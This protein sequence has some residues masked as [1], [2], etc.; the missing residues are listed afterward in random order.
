MPIQAITRGRAAGHFQLTGH[1]R[2]SLIN[3]G[4][5]R[6]SHIKRKEASHDP[7][8]RSRALPPTLV[9]DGEWSLVQ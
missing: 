2:V 7:G 4:F 1:Q 8:W 3:S 6:I 9:Q 5:H